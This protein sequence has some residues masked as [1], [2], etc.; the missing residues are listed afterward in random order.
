MA[1]LVRAPQR[2]LAAGFVQERVLRLFVAFGLLMAYR[3]LLRSA[4]EMCK[5]Q[6][7][8][9]GEIILE[10]PAASLAA[11]AAPPGAAEPPGAAAAAAAHPHEE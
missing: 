11:A 3:A 8:K 5:R 2:L 7:T 4:R 10:P 1:G 6:L 9:W